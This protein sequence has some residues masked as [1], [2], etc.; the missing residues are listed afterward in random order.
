MAVAG[1]QVGEEVGD[2]GPL[3]LRGAAVALGQEGA[4]LEQIGSIGRERVVRQAP[5]EFQVREEVE[6]QRLE[7]RLDRA[8]ALLAATDCDRHAR[9]FSPPRTIPCRCNRACEPTD[10]AQV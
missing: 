6:H 5:L 1:R 9:L 8:A 4:V 2:I 7:A 3:G 10:G